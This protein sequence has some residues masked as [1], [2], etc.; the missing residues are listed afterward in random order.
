MRFTKNTRLVP[1]RGS[2]IPELG[3]NFKSIASVNRKNKNKMVDIL[4]ICERYGQLLPV[5]LISGESGRARE[6]FLVDY[7]GE[8][9]HHDLLFTFQFLNNYCGY[10]FRSW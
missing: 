10:Y 9:F 8:V 2:D 7:T 3:F 6:L 4:A 1:S 5:T